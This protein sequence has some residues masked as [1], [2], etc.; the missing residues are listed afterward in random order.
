[1]AK[2]L[3][4]GIFIAQL[5][6]LTSCSKPTEYEEV[7][8]EY[9][10]ANYV[11]DMDK[12]KQLCVPEAAQLFDYKKLTFKQNPQFKEM[13]KKATC[14]VVK[15]ELVDSHTALVTL[16]ESNVYVD[17]FQDENNPKLVA[18]QQTVLSLV[19]QNNKWLVQIR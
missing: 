9:M 14:E 2:Y 19:K 8:K 5:V 15:S 4:V 11:G 18:V 12:A 7:A 6:L 1:M 13:N 16:E 17:N 3:T 10:Q